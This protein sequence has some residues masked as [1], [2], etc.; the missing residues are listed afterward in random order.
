MRFRRLGLAVVLLVGVVAA[1]CGDSG[2]S[3]GG[4]TGGTS[5]ASTTTAAPKTGGTVTMGVFAQAAGLDPVIQSGT[6]VAGGIELSAIYDT[7]MRYNPQTAKYEPRIAESLTPNADF[8][9]WTLKLRPNV[10]FS[11]GSDFNADAVVFNLKRHVEKKSRTVTLV[12]P[13]KDY[14]TP[15]PLTVVFTLNSAWSGFPFALAS[16]PGM[17][18]SPAAIQKL[19]DSLATNPVGAGAG[20]F[21]IDSFK[22]NESITLKR[23]PNYWGG[24]VYL[25]GLKFV[26]IPGASQT[27]EALKAGTLQA[28]FLRDPK[29]VA[30]AQA[31]GYTGYE[32]VYSAGD[33]M[34]MNN[35]VK[36]ACKGGQPAPICTGQADGAMVPTLSPTTDKRV[37][38]A[39]A[40]A[41][42]ADNIN[43][44]L[45]DG[46]AKYD[47][48]L[49]WKTSR[50]YDNIAG[51]KYD[52]E[53]AKKLVAEVKAEGKWD[54]SIRVMCHN[55]S[56]QWG[57]AVATLLQAAGFNPTVIDQRD[58]QQNI[59]DVIV[60]R[61]YDLACFGT[62]ISDEEPF[63]ALNRDLN[64]QFNG[65]GAGN[66]VG[67]V[68]PTVDQALAQGRAAKSD[69]EAKA[70]ID[71]IAKAY[72]ADIPF[73][74]MGASTEYV[75]TQKN[76]QGITPSVS[77]LVFFD[78]AFL[79]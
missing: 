67:Y 37:R 2:T 10:K 28:A 69:A 21:V 41:I 4:Q 26:F 33:T 71:T 1:G 78:K 56:P 30:D 13:I 64:S 20:P 76:L 25:D 38:Q 66:F 42:N 32:A 6:G 70:A 51:P 29:V 63:F 43:Q 58:V 18:V 60:K 59:A 77:T 68:N 55:G 50:W 9:Q 17:I 40:A 3:S 48:G 45:Y 16:A 62:T 46:K 5:A 24:Q 15:D 54:G 74:T 49:I 8:T 52:L 53:Q 72:T 19:G 35:G 44:R 31:A 14:A 34:L 47:S 22:V 73:L 61:D 39:V 12:Q 27:Y 65:T 23:N 75:A 57:T 11:D 79:A 36:V 7:L